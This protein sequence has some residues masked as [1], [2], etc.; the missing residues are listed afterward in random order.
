MFS[1]R[2]FLA[3]TLLATTAASADITL[4][5]TFGNAAQTNPTA[6]TLTNTWSEGANLPEVS[7]S[8]TSLTNNSGQDVTIMASTTTDTAAAAQD[9]LTPNSNVGTGSPW[10]LTMNYSSRSAA[11]EPEIA[12]ITLSVVLFASNGR[13]QSSDAQWRDPNDTTEPRA[14]RQSGYLDF[15]ANLQ[16]GALTLGTF[17]G[18]M[19]LRQGQGDTSFSVTLT[20]N[21]PISLDEHTD[22]TV[23]LGITP[24]IDAGTYVGLNSISYTLVPEPT[25]ALLTLPALGALLLRRRRRA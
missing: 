10:T 9:V 14:D 16:D 5:T 25:T 24:N 17:T 1:P 11:I 15:T 19:P 4:T 8:I 7:G 22:F 21:K 2:Y 20:P 23:T 13:Y 12:S 18:R 3:C 6:V